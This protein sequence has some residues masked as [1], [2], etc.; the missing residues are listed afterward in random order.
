MKLNQN[1]FY[2][3]FLTVML[4]GTNKPVSA[5][6]IYVDDSA[7]GMDNGTSWTDA[8][9]D[10]QIAMQAATTGDDLWVVASTF[11][12]TSGLDRDTTF[13]FKNQIDLYGGFLGSETSITQRD[14]NNHTILSGNIGDPL[15]SL[16][17]SK[18]VCWVTDWYVEMTLDGFILEDGYTAF[19]SGAAVYTHYG[20]ITFKNCI[21]RNNY[22]LYGGAICSTES[23][24]Y[25]FDCI[26]ED[27]RGVW[28]GAYQC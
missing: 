6:V 28:G 7:T 16:D 15:D 20:Y 23:T 13:G 22:T 18:H 9:T 8:Y 26:F 12:P 2:Y 19:S 27:N 1:I 24:M 10:L 5:T 3:L 17:N 11:Y 25:Y 4:L 14:P 21:F